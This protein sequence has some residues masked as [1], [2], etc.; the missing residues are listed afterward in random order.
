MA[1]FLNIACNLLAGQMEITLNVLEADLIDTPLEFNGGQGYH[2][3]V[4]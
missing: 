3:L 2:S 1:L 4:S